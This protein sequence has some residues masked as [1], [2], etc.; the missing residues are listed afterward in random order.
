MRRRVNSAA[1]WPCLTQHVFETGYW[2]AARMCG[3]PCVCA[4][5]EEGVCVDIARDA[6]GYGEQRKGH[7]ACDRYDVDEDMA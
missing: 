3:V 1:I 2:T 7:A 5:I 6:R 4:D